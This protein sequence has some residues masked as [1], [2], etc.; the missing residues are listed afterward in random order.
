MNEDKIDAAI[1]ALAE[2]INTTVGADVAMKL[3]QAALNLAHV[4]STL[5]G[6]RNL[7]KPPG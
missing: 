4:K 3:S 7:E 1:V 6:I 5:A 2:R